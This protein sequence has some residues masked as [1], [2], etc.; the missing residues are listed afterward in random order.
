MGACNQ[1][2]RAMYDAAKR[3]ANSPQ[4]KNASA[5]LNMKRAAGKGAEEEDPD[6]DVGDPEGEPLLPPLVP[7][8]S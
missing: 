4:H 2:F 8:K 3:C 5:T 6:N 7:F 1:R